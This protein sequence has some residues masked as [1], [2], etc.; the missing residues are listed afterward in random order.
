MDSNY[1]AHAEHADKLDSKKSETNTRRDIGRRERNMHDGLADSSEQHD[2]RQSV[3][4]RALGSCRDYRN[5]N[6]GV[7]RQV[8][9]GI[10]VSAYRPPVPVA[11]L[12]LVGLEFLNLGP[13][14]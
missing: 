14:R 4:D 1:N 6:S 12:W 10:G 5:N 3:Q 11:S 2:N 7:D 8:F 13:S 9:E